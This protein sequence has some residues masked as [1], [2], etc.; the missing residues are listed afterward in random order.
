MG[1]AVHDKEQQVNYLKN[2][3][4]M[5]MSVIDSLDP[6]STDLEDIDRLIGM[7]D[8]LEAKYERFKK[9]WK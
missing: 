9:D 8:D 3:L 7:L 1:N 5:F 2:R 6:E 4:D